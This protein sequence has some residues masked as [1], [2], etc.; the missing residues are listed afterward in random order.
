[1]NQMNNV[2]EYTRKWALTSLIVLFGLQMLRV[3]FPT[4]AYYL[5]DTQGVS[6]LTLGPIA[7][8]VFALS[9]LAGPLKALLGLRRA[10]IVA[11]GG[12]A[13]LRLAEQI[14]FNP[15]LDVFLAIGAGEK[16][17]N[18]QR[19]RLSPVVEVSDGG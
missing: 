19:I 16:Y 7:I 1:M 13:L 18:G 2:R 12:T 8:G 17:V 14:S 10:L 5:R 9:F 11:A 6:A 4:F 15:G 3:L